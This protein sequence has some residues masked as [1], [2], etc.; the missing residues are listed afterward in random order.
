L[1]ALDLQPLVVKVFHGQ[2]EQYVVRG[3]YTNRPSRLQFTQGAANA[4]VSL[5]AKHGRFWMRARGGQLQ[6]FLLTGAFV[7]HRKS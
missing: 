4:N 1:L 6:G 2:C 3:V 7:E 5:F